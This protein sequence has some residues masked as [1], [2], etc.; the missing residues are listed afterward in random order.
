MG[1]APV[2]RSTNS[3]S[4]I[5]RHSPL[6]SRC[7]HVF[8]SC[9]APSHAR[10]NGERLHSLVSTPLESGDR[11]ALVSDKYKSMQLPCQRGGVALEN[12][13]VR[14]MLSKSK[15]FGRGVYSKVV[16]L[17]LVMPLFYKAFVKITFGFG[18]PYKMLSSSKGINY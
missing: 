10:P 12:Y 6:R 17:G 3:P 18:K 13:V 4:Y 5:D 8:A 14:F 2:S 9:S 11:Q 16:F 1:I 7:L 15:H